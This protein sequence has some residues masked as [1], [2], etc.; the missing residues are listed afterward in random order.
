M[1]DKK[2]IKYLSALLKYGN[3]SKA[4]EVLFTS[5]PSLSRYLK[6]IEF[7][8]GF[9]IFDRSTSP[10]KLT[11]K[12]EIYAKY[13]EKFLDLELDMYNEIRNIDDKKEEIRISSLPFL[14][15]YVYPKFIPE[16]LNSNSNINL[17]ISDYQEKN[18]EYLLLNNLVDI[19]IT[20]F[21]PKQKALKYKLVKS[22]TIYIICK[23]NKIIESKYN[24]QHNSIDNPLNINFD[25]FQDKTF[26]LLNLSENVGAASKMI[27]NQ[28]NFFPKK[29]T[30]VPNI[31]SSVSMLD[32][33]SATFITE[34]SL[35][36]VHLKKDVIFFKTENYN[37][38]LSIGFIYHKDYNI[39]FVESFYKSMKK[40]LF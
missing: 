35:T 10:F 19:F 9:K 29:I 18:Y 6:S 12:G 1:L 32:E 30:Y 25:E 13:L 3:V 36:Y 28:N 5:Q 39:E 40:A 2:Q 15:S 24:L 27:L 14:S 17:V 20:N 23:K 34:S 33:N 21:R 4:S 26:Y 11:K 7:D 8:L 22:D 37:D 16:F 38:F 31:L